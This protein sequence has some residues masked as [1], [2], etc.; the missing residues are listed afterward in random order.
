MTPAR[1]RGAIRRSVSRT[2]SPPPLVR[3][4]RARRGRGAQIGRGTG[5]VDRRPGGHQR[6]V[7]RRLRPAAA[8]DLERDAGVVGRL[9]AAQ[10]GRIALV[11]PEVGREPSSWVRTRAVRQ[12]GDEGAPAGANSSRPPAPCTTIARFEPSAPCASARISQRSR[13]K[14]PL[15]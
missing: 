15:T 8:Q 13:L 11:E 5:D 7:A 12:L 9:A 3:T 14:M 4:W 1:G 6:R 10:A 2:A